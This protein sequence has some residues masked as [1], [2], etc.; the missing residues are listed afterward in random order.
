MQ[1]LRQDADRRL[2]VHPLRA[3]PLAKASFLVCVHV[4]AKPLCR[5]I[6]WG[7]RGQHLHITCVF[8]LALTAAAC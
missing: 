5:G 2:H 6:K 1:S 3:R 4:F 8:H 7:P